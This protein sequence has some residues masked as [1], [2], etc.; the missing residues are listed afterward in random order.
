MDFG[1]A[2]LGSLHAD[3]LQQA[4]AVGAGQLQTAVKSA[5]A[6]GPPKDFFNLDKLMAEEQQRG[7]GGVAAPATPEPH[8]RPPPSDAPAAAPAPSPPPPPPPP[9]AARARGASTSGARAPAAATLRT[10]A[11]A[12][13]LATPQQAAEAAL[14][15]DLESAGVIDD[16]GLGD[17]AFSRSGTPTG[18]L[19]PRASPTNRAGLVVPPL[20]LAALVAAHE[21]AN[22]V[23]RP[24]AAAGGPFSFVTSPPS[25][26]LFSALQGGGGGGGG[27]TGLTAVAGG[28]DAVGSFLGKAAASVAAGASSAAAGA[29]SAASSLGT[30]VGAGMT[31][32]PGSL[33]AA[34]AH[35]A[36][37]G[38]GSLKRISAAVFSSPGGA[39]ASP[40]SDGGGG[41]GGGGGGDGTPSKGILKFSLGAGVGLNP[42]HLAASAPR[43]DGGGGG[44]GG[45]GLAARACAG[46]YRATLGRLE[47][48]FECV[49]LPALL[50][51]R[52]GG[53]ALA[54]LCGCCGLKPVV[55]AAK[56]AAGRFTE[57]QLATLLLLVAA[58]W[59]AWSWG[60]LPSLP[61]LAA[62]GGSGGAGAGSGPAGMAPL[63]A[64]REGG[65]GGGGGGGGGGVA[66]GPPV[67]VAAPPPDPGA[68]GVGTPG[69]GGGSGGGALTAPGELGVR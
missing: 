69:G 15:A 34:F 44:G 17:R 25:L 67:V 10:S 49:L 39:K 58:L 19:T 4:L 42:A 57:R 27:G 48:A 51:V 61:S 6:V 46:A 23:G 59:L 50:A 33:H 1:R 8:P 31:A 54:L 29:A 18:H 20:P 68:G 47:P 22:A 36:L 16:L 3:R 41:G 14:L 38:A 12:L 11:S 30:G 13:A 66:A 53:P 28:V 45:G 40:V 32:L 55:I 7:S 60:A 37:P 56:R 62:A 52:L 43:A 63:T 5:A 9:P 24:H 65:V 35:V 64:A 26:S 2:L 21:S